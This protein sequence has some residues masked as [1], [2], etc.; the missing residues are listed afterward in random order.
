MVIAAVSVLRGPQRNGIN[1][2]MTPRSSMT[3]VFD[4]S[5]KKKHI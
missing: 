1:E 5:D 3:V 4:Y 2:R